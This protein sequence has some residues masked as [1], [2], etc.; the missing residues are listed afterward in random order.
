[1]GWNEMERERSSK[2][3]TFPPICSAHKIH[4]ILLQFGKKLKIA[5]SSVFRLFSLGSFLG[6]SIILKICYICKWLISVMVVL[7]AFCYHCYH[8]YTLPAK[9]GVINI[10]GEI[11]KKKVHRR[12]HLYGSTEVINP[13]SCKFVEGELF[14][15]KLLKKERKK[16][17]E[18]RKKKRK[19]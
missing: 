1:M 11:Y 5:N 17:K 8:S 18:E 12:I 3:L 15:S 7:W 13:R 19:Q 2:I 14:H 10:I 9:Q 16:Q 6:S 4:H